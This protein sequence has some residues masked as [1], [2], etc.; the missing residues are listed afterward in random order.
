[1]TNAEDAAA[2]RCADVALAR[3]A[4][5][6]AAA[7]AARDWRRASPAPRAAAAPRRAAAPALRAAA[8]VALL[9]LL[10]CCCARDPAHRV[11]GRGGEVRLPGLRWRE[12]CAR[13]PA[14]RFRRRRA[15]S[16]AACEWPSRN[17]W[18]QADASA[19]RRRSRSGTFPEA[20]DG[21]RAHCSTRTVR[22]GSPRR[23]QMPARSTAKCFM[24]LPESCSTPSKGRGSATNAGLRESRK[25]AVPQRFGRRESFPRR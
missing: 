11:T 24:V 12:R 14:L 10:R 16:A 17:R 9:L 6:C 1:M 8:A 25:L 15:R 2:F 13:F 19:A 18:A 22:V 7:T 21:S 23:M 4:P 20:V 3:R 5:A